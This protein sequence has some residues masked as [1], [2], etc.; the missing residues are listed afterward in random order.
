[1]NNHLLRTGTAI[2]IIIIGMIMQS[3]T[4]SI[5]INGFSSKEWKSDR[6]GCKRMRT[7]SIEYLMD[8]KE[9]IMGQSEHNVLQLLGRPDKNELLTRQ[10]KFYIYY[11][12]PGPLCNQSIQASD[13]AS[14]L[15]IHFNATGIVNEVF[16]YE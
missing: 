4:S 15:S 13:S 6:N 7:S 14:Y 9:N 3:C 1:M 16:V 11:L 8:S 2:V 12:E 5:E 10:Q